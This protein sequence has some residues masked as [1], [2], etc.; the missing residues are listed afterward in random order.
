MNA[1]YTPRRLRAVTKQLHILVHNLLNGAT[2]IKQALEWTCELRLVRQHI[3]NKAPS[4]R[5]AFLAHAERYLRMFLPEAAFDIVESTRYKD[6]TA[7]L[8]A[9][10]AN[11][12]ATS[13]DPARSTA[14]PAPRS[15]RSSG[16]PKVDM[17]VRATRA[18]NPGE[19]IPRLTGGFLELSN[20]EDERMKAEADAAREGL[21]PGQIGTS[22]VPARDFSVIRS[23]QKKCSLLLLGPARFVNHDCRANVTF[24]PTQNGM[25]F[26]CIRRIEAGE[27][28][29][30]FYGLHYF[31]WDN[32]E[33][34]AALINDDQ[35]GKGGYSKG[36]GYDKIPKRHKQVYKRLDT[37]NKNKKAAH[38]AKAEVEAKK[39][40]ELRKGHGKGGDLI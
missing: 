39:K 20:E 8:Q 13:S 28:I 27:E 25:T 10:A 21:Q 15:Y 7:R 35:G 33:C 29:T 38:K 5:N 26:R 17:A 31:E 18:Y 12:Y 4:Q 34:I 24:V 19:F 32:A 11:P 14:P 2:S 16:A 36:G 40:H 9:A 30:C 22:A 6:T 23:L 37:A 3:A 1:D